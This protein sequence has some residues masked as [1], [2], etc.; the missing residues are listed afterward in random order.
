M[1]RIIFSDIDGTLLNSDQS[2]SENMKKKIKEL[3]SRDIPFVLASS[4]PENGVFSIMDELKIKAPAISYSGALV[5]DGNRKVIRSLEIPAKRAQE[6]HDFIVNKDKSVCCCV[7][8]HEL[9]LTDDKNDEWL[10]KEEEI[11]GLSSFQGRISDF[12]EYT[13]VHKLLCMG[14]KQNID[15]IAIQLERAFSDVYICRSKDTYLEINH[16]M[17]TKANAMRFLCDVMGISLSRT[18]AFGDGEVDLEMIQLAGKGFVMRNAP[19]KVRQGA[20]YIA[21]SNDNEGILKALIN[22]GF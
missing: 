15:N 9:W 4:R 21:E 19:D 3:E 1:R 2:I 5:H 6:I 20:K 10:M 16:P 22:I 18:V 17:A 12:P 13:G 7:Y 14:N 8:S 11:T